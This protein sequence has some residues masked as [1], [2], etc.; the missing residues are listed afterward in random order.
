VQPRGEVPNVE[1]VL[2]DGSGESITLVFL[3]RRSIGGLHSGSVLRVEGMVGK[4]RG[5]LAM[6]NPSFEFASAFQTEGGH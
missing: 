3:G 6:I 4:H 5:R 2:V 1:C